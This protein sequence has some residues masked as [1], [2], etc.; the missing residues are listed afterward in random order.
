MS[1]ER[2]TTIEEAIRAAVERQRLV[3]LAMDTERDRL[4]QEREA[5]RQANRQPGPSR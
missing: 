2:P 1:N 3:R 5:A 4:A